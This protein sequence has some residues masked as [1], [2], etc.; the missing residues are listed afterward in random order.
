MSPHCIVG[1][2]L[3]QEFYSICI[4]ACINSFIY[5]LSFYFFLQ[6]LGDGQRYVMQEKSSRVITRYEIKKEIKSVL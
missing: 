3:F 6:S 4:L 2:A 1:I 5:C